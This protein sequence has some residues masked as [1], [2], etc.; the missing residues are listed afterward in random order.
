MSETNPKVE[1]AV[2]GADMRYERKFV[3]ETLGQA[4]LR[5]FLR[6]HPAGFF[7]PY[8]VRAVNNLYLESLD[9]RG[10]RQS[11]DGDPDRVKIR[12]RW[13]GEPFGRV[14]KPALE[15]KIKRGLVGHKRRYALAPF[16]M[17][18][19]F[20]RHK[21]R[22][23]VSAANP[24]ADLLPALVASELQLMNGYRRRYFESRDRRFRVTL[25]TG[26]WF[27]RLHPLR[28]EFMTRAME[29][30]LVVMELK[31]AREDDEHA[32]QVMQH[33]PMRLTKSSKFVVGLDKVCLW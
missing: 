24:P 13:Y 21:L 5:A 14:E 7:E 25:D 19:S 17:D 6:L 11:V 20:D 26:L 27:C 18:E 15:F 2:G 1:A 31:Y 16:T 23:L 9:Y 10:Y 3:P 29:H 22:E 28:N 32:H 8:P 30:D 12:L 33:F 4:E